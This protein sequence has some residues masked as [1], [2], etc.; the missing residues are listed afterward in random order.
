MAVSCL[1]LGAGD[2]VLVPTITYVACFQAIRATGATPVACDV[3]P[4]DIFIDPADAE[5]RITG[6]T[7]AIMPV[8]YA[9][10]AAG[11]E[12]IYSLAR[13]HGLRVIEDAAHSFGADR[14]GAKVGAQGDIVCFSFDG[15]KNIT[16][17]EGGAVVTSDAALAQK[18]SDARL[19]GVER[20]T[21]ARYAAQ[22]SWN[23]DVH[24]QGFRYHMSNLMA[25]VGR[26]Q[27]QKLPGFAAR[28]VA[29][30]K[31]YRDALAPMNTLGLLDLEWDGMV[32][33][34]FV[35]RV[36][37]GRR[38]ELAAYLK[39]QGIETGFHYQPN[40]KLSLFASPENL[41]ASETVAEELLTLPLHVGM[42]DA[43]QERIVTAIQTF[44][45]P[46]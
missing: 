35:A 33:H 15:I 45:R 32:P 27:L 26:A 20:D 3:R 12:D 10:S 6:R 18:L 7:K 34:I 22:R 1:D 40:H 5:R 30:A 36:L 16:S 19:L 44:Y 23:F 39:E 14:K 8:H 24:Q 4:G 37:G 13:K 42:S 28:R 46:R 31:R 11:L 43:D 38:A 41:P 17:G 21:E 2:E 29:L 25:A 9:G